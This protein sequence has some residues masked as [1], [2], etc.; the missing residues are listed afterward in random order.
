MTINRSMKESPLVQGRHEIITYQLTST[1]W[2]SAPTDINVVVYDITGAG[3]ANEWQ[4]VTA[5]VMPVNSPT[6]N[7]DV[8]TLS[9]L[10]LLEDGHHYRLEVHFTSGANRFEPHCLI[11]G[12]E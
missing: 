10:S 5:I 8:I 11:F 12:G 6:I 9:P 7:G 3:H 4:D 1:P 2:G